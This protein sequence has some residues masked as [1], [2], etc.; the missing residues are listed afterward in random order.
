MLLGQENKDGE[1]IEVRRMRNAHEGTKTNRYNIDPLDLLDLETE[2]DEK[3]LTMIGIYH[4]HP[5]HPSRPSQYDLGNAW[6][7]L[8]YFVVSI[9][10]GK[11]AKLTS[12]R[13][14][15]DRSLFDE[16][17]VQIAN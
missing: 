11:A 7:N 16:E 14:N 5:D 9:E 3:G 12:W 15:N 6:P 17:Y 10:K 2:I 4:S 1:V 13:L 8:S